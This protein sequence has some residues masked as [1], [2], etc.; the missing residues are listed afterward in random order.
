MIKFTAQRGT[1][2]LIGFGLSEGNLKRMKQGRPIH[3]HG[4]EIGLLRTEI[5]IFYGKTEQSMQQDLS[6][7]IGPETRI[8]TG[9]KH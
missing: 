5:M 1:R 2:K 4:E 6:E 3:V 7:F 8:H 9:D